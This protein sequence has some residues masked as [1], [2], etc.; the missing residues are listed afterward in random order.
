[1]QPDYRTLLNTAW[2][3]HCAPRE[4]TAP[5]CMSLFTGGGG[6]A[7][8]FSMAGYRT[9]LAVE[10]AP[11][12]VATFLANH[13][14]ASLHFGNVQD[15]TTERALNL[16]GVDKGE[17]DVIEAS[18]PCQ[19]FSS[20]GARHRHDP[21]NA[22][23]WDFVRLTSGMLPKAFV[24][25][26]VPALL[27]AGTGGRALFKETAAALSRRGYHVAAWV[28]D[29]AY[30]NVPQH[31]RRLFLTGIRKDIAQAPLTPPPTESWPRPLAAAI[32][33]FPE[34]EIPEIGHVW[35]DESP[36][37]RATRTWRMAAGA[38]QGAVYAG[39]QRRMR[40]DAP[41]ATI[42][43]CAANGRDK[44]PYLRNMHCHPLAT[45]TFSPAELKRIASFPDA[46]HFA[47]EWR[48]AVSR[49]G[50]AVP[51]FLMRAV[52]R[53][54]LRAIR[55]GKEQGGCHGRKATA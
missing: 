22:L 4:M 38:P 9:L 36:Q 50:N 24:M 23:V 45:R 47:G 49:I 32:A 52:A 16:C 35:V 1:M 34:Q 42:T 12:A 5:S 27:N 14:Q 28:L 40:W 37:G 48:H 2:R 55:G 15:L 39:Y 7:L 18:P 20:A 13:P 31:R 3:A 11:N 41:C 8:G 19:G 46:Y 10:R 33:D 21:R 51:P 54:L 26:N 29:A 17:L 25:E 44:R 30:F 53:H 6:S 43:A